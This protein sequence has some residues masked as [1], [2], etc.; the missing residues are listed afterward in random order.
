MTFLNALGGWQWA[1]LALIP[2]AILALYFLKLRRQPETVPSTYLWARTVEDL[3][4]NSLWQRLRRNLLLLLQLLVIFLIMLAL[5]RP[6]WQGTQLTDNRFIF[7]IDTSASMQATDVSPSR[8]DDAKRQ[9]ENLIDRM[10][11]GDVAMLLTSSN[12]ARVEQSYTDN[13]RLLKQRLAEIEATNRTS[14]LEEA[15]RYADG[16]ANPGRSSASETDVQAAEPMPATLFIL[17]DGGYSTVP[18]FFLGNL[19]PQYFPIGDPEVSNVGILAFSAERNPE[20]PLQTQA[21]ARLQNFGLSEVTIEVTLSLDGRLVDAR[22]ATIEP[23]DFVGLSF[24]LRDVSSGILTL[25]IDTPD[26]LAA[27]NTAHAVLQPPRRT[28]LLV[29]TPGNDALQLALTTRE[30]EKLADTTFAPPSFLETDNYRQQAELGDFDVI[31]YDRCSPSELPQ[32]STLFLGTLPPGDAWT[33]GE[34]RDVPLIVDSDRA[35][36][37]MQL[38]DLGNIRVARGRSV[39]PPPSGRSLL[40]ADLGPL[41]AVAPRA[42]FEDAV[43]GFE[44][45]SEVDGS[46]QANTDWP[47]RR[48]FPIFF[49][50][51]IRH[52]GRTHLAVSLSSV[53][54][55]Q[56]VTLP[57]ETSSTNLFVETPGGERIELYSEAGEELVFTRTEELGVYAVHQADVAEPI[58]HFAVNLFN[59]RESNLTPESEI[60]LE[61]ES[62]AAQ[63]SLEPVRA[64]IWKSLLLLVL[65][66]LIFEWYVYNRRVYL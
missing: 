50:N 29:V 60:R 13:R 10:K 3:H 36:P 4:V 66:V 12:Y 30:F 63:S 8:L 61:H 6:G 62:I 32:A 1:L 43:L 37:M 2:P 42:S 25:Q 57:A 45:L 28:R 54:P 64:E 52:L 51:A 58:Q 39:Q 40:D 44:L 27:D 59:A 31:L 48:S 24:E 5:L 26:A 18:N 35:H 41:L 14:D 56:P 33:A 20:D 21:Y 49:M 38:I 11:S 47:I 22:Q 55:G 34:L 15:L 9:V 16:L 7:L 53:S 17:S 19:S 46:V 65:G 23:D